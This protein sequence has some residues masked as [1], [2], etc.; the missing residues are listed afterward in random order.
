VEEQTRSRTLDLGWKRLGLLV[1]G[2]WAGSGMWGCG[3]ESWM[4]AVAASRRVTDRGNVMEG[5]GS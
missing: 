4:R 2:A 1:E 5:W 3:K